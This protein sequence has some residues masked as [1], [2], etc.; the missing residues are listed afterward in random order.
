MLLFYTKNFIFYT[1]FLNLEKKIGIKNGVKKQ[2]IGVNKIWCK[3]GRP[4]FHL[5]YL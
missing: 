4:L 5:G 3:K 1:K 2:K